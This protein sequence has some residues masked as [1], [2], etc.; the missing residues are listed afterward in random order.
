M[1][2]NRMAER[3]LQNATADSDTFVDVAILHAPGV[4]RGALNA[5]MAAGWIRP[6]MMDGLR[7][8]YRITPAGRAALAAFDDGQGNALQ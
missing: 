6:D 3:A 4:G 7:Q 5:F 2:K 1:R 8:T